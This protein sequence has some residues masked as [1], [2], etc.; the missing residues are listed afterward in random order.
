MRPGHRWPVRKRHP[1]NPLSPGWPA[2]PA[3]GY[4]NGNPGAQKPAVA[5]ARNQPVPERRLPALLQSAPSA[6]CANGAPA[7]S[8]RRVPFPDVT[9]FHHTAAGLPYPPVPETGSGRRSRRYRVDR[10]FPPLKYPDI[11]LCPDHL[12]VKSPV[13]GCW[14]LS[15]EH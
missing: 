4:G 8:R 7:A 2:H 10:H 5:P 12:S 3:A 13:P 14:P 15:P 11:S 9:D 6:Q 1:G